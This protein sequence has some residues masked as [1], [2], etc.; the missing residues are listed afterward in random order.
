MRL[1]SKRKFNQ[2][3]IDRILRLKWLSR[4]AQLVLAGNDLVTI[5]AIL[6]DELLDSFQSFQKGVRG[7]L[8]KTLTILLKIWV[9]PS[10]DLKTL[11]KKGLDFIS[12]LPEKDHLAVHWG[13]LMATYPFWGRV[14]DQVGRLLRLQGQFKIAQVQRRLLEQYGERQTVSRAAQRVLRSFVDWGVLRDGLERGTYVS[15]MEHS[16]GN[17]A[18]LAWLAEA[19]LNASPNGSIPFQSILNSTTLFPFRFTEV[20]AIQLAA[21][22]ENLVL[23]RHGLDEDLVMLREIASDEW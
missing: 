1:S 5:K 4:T 13:M 21:E 2:V 6:Q 8:D 10:D 17:L 14:A 15:G 22:N 19:F 3:G 11:H 18:L 23:L 20:S 16:V 12:R 7:S 9:R